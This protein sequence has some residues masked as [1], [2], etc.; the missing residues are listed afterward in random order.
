MSTNAA[1]AEQQ[2]PEGFDVCAMGG[3]FNAAFGPIY[4][5]RSEP[6]LGFRVGPQHLNPVGT[7]HGGAM[8]TFADMM[9]VAVHDGAGTSE[10]H[11]PTINLTVDYLGPARLGQWV[12]MPVALARATKTMYFTQSIITADGEPAA[13]VHGIYRRYG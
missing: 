4:R 5:H 3:G 1:P 2:V 8:A 10:R 13:R 7:V 12:E 6:R 11:A 9:V